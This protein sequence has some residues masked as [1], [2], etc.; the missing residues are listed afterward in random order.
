MLNKLVCLIKILISLM[1]K[2]DIPNIKIKVQVFD[3][4]MYLQWYISFLFKSLLIIF[5]LNKQTPNK[6]NLVLDLFLV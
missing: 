6:K 3:E 2:Q 5:C 1:A 4:N